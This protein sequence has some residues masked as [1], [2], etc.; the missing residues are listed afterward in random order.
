MTRMPASGVGGGAASLIRIGGYTRRHHPGKAEP[1]KPEGSSGSELFV[2]PPKVG[3][4]PATLM[5]VILS[6]F[7]KLDGP[8]DLLAGTV[9]DWA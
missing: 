2:H 3:G 9:D 6:P 1:P 5:F 7:P 4:Q 8:N